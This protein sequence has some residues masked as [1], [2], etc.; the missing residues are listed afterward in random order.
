MAS[1]AD[2]AETVDPISPETVG[3]VVFDRFRA[4]AGL[5]VIP[6]V[7]GGGRPVA[8]VERER[9][10]IRLAAEFG[11]ALYAKRPISMIMDAAPLVVE[12]RTPLSEFTHHALV[13]QPSELNRGFVIVR[14]GVYCGVGSLLGLLQAVS[15]DNARRV[16]EMTELTDSLAVARSAATTAHEQMREAVDCM[17]ESLAFFDEHDRLVLW[18]EKYFELH[19]ECRHLLEVGTPFRAL[20]ESGIDQEYYGLTS[21]EREQ[22]LAD[23]LALHA[24]PA[25][26]HEQHL[27][28]GRWLL[29]QE[30]RTPRGGVVSVCVDITDDKTREVMLATA[31]DEAE[32]ANRAKTEFLAN[33]SHEIRTPL[34]GVLG[35][36]QVLAGTEL[37]DR[38]REM[39][40]IITSSAGALQTILSD[41]LDVARVEAGQL[42][43]QDEAFDLRKAVH[44]AWS[45]AQLR[46][47]E[48]GLTCDLLVEPD[49]PHWVAGDDARLKQVLTN[50]LS[51]AVKFT[52]RG[53][54]ALT[55][56]TQSQEGAPTLV[57]RVSDTG[58]GISQEALA[59]LF[60][61][62]SQADGGV[63]RRFGGSGLG[64]AI[65][66][67]LARLMGGRLE[68]ASAETVG[69]TFT[70]TLPLRLA[71]APMVVSPPPPPPEV[72]PDGEAPLR[73]L[74]AEDNATNRKVVG[75]ILET[76]GVDLHC[77][78]NGA[79][80]LRALETGRYDL[81]LMDLQMPVMD[82]LTAIAHI[83][84]REA[85][86]NE[87]PMP[88]IVLSANAM[89]ENVQASLAAGANGHLSKPIA[90]SDLITAV[91]LALA[92]GSTLVDATA[93]AAA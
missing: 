25:S 11:R 61:R 20:I 65:S 36:A 87:P 55:V 29:V 85:A 77:V 38:Q 10:M 71:E 9:F 46:A 73:I 23:R 49:V 57:F 13:H 8:I 33:M 35:V 31:R 12:A 47:E 66:R 53:R 62:F 5:L 21:A 68:A 1:L 26:R 51:N 40:E 27:K 30:R 76:V 48:K 70:L 4:E 37:A 6:V 58:M 54:L 60:T 63:T 93:A 2:I 24:E 41:I 22:F 69:S 19:P 83:R 86:S 32:A 7:D 64:L 52:D 50:L 45:L 82:G 90:A 42:P 91:G 28:D 88:V 34:N 89:P 44:G 14:D 75:L 59:R 92:P 79:E 80:A 18:N 67:D 84:R 15:A 74:L 3:E 72:G 56:A 43:I 81:V 39:V 16:Q 78:E 17:P